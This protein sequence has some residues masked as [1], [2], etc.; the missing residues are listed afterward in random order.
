MVGITTRRNPDGLVLYKGAKNAKTGLP[1][2][3]IH[4]EVFLDRD[5]CEK[6]LESI[7]EAKRHYWRNG[8]KKPMKPDKGSILKV[9]LPDSLREADKK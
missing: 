7:R 5:E 9:E 4:V 6:V 1:E 2:G 3:G 8:E